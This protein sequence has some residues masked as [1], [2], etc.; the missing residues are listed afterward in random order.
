MKKL[1]RATLFALVTGLGAGAAESAS[2]TDA[3]VA[4]HLT[5][6]PA[7]NPQAFI[8]QDESPN[9]LNIPCSCYT[10]DG[11]TPQA[12][13]LYLVVAGADPTDTTEALGDGILGVAL[14][15]AYNGTQSVGVDVNQWTTC[16]DLEFPNEWPAAGGDNVLAWDQCQKTVIA[17]DDLH[18]VVGAFS[19]YAYSADQF[20]I[21]PNND[22]AVIPTLTAADCNGAQWDLR[23]GFTARVSF[24]PANP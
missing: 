15:I 3:K 13:S 16:S 23:P 14:G 8:C 4:L 19:I 2:K 17:P 18:V 22:G 24:D 20:T 12:Y 11:T 5:H 1:Y 7:K 9:T 6:P 21:T 10:V